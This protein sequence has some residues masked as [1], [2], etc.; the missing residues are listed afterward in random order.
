LEKISKKKTKIGI[1]GDFM[2]DKYIFGHCD[3]ISPEAP[4]PIVKCEKTYSSLGGAGN[5]GANITGLGANIVPIGIIGNDLDG[6]ELYQLLGQTT[7]SLNNVVRSDDFPTIAKTRVIANDQQVVRID[8]ES[9]DGEVSERD[10]INR[11]DDIINDVDLFVISDYGKGTC[12]GRVMKHLI[13]KSNMV[14]KTVLV[15]PRKSVADFSSYQDAT[16]I[17]PNFYETKSLIHHISNTDEDIH[18]SAE[19]ISK[20]YNIDNVIITRG[21]KGMTLLSKGNS[22]EHFPTQAKEVFDVSGAGDTVIA[23]I[24][25]CIAA[26]LNLIQ[27]SNIANIAAGIVVSHM[28]TTPIKIEELNERVNQEY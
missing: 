22:I 26:G 27:S 4:V 3:R 1:Y 5:V 14:G 17:T 2:L 11:I 20:N 23:T 19:Q 16:I 9:M 25:V 24:S 28:G 18:Y 12:P 7:D 10:L 13:R 6:D 21:N 15:D 8:N